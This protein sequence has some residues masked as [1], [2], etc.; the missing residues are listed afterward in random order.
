MLDHLLVNLQLFLQH[1]HKQ[2]FNQAAVLIR[3]YK[4]KEVLVSYLKV[5][6]EEMSEINSIATRGS[7]GQV[8]I[9]LTQSQNMRIPIPPLNEVRR[10]IEEVSKY[11]ILIDFAQTKILLTFKIL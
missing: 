8:N 6:L 10:I 4:F 2:I 3:P 9:S 1:C 5:Y 7:A 11:D